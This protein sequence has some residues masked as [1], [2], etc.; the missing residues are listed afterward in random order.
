MSAKITN[1]ACLLAIAALALCALLVQGC[2]DSTSSDAPVSPAAP[3]NAPGANALANEKLAAAPPTDTTTP[4]PQ[5]TI[6][7]TPT[8]VTTPDHTPTPSA[9]P[10]PL[11]PPTPMPTSTLTPMS[12]PAPAAQCS[13]GVAVPN[14][15]NTPRLV[16]DCSALLAARDTLAGT[17][18]NLNWSSDIPISDWDG[19]TIGND[20]VSSLS[21]SHHRLDGEIPPELGNLANLEML[22]LFQNRLTGVIPPELGNLSNLTDLHLS[23][24][25]LTGEI[26]PELGN[27]SNLQTLFLSGNHLTGAI[28]PELG[29]LANLTELSLYRNELTRAIPPELGDLANLEFLYL[30]DNQLTG[31]IPPELGNLA[32]LEILHLV[33]NQLTSEIPPELGNLANLTELLLYRNELTGAIPPELGDLANLTELSLFSN[34]LTGAIPP[35]L[36]NLA[37]LEILYLYGNQLKGEIPQELGS[38]ANLTRLFLYQNELTDEI[39]PALGNLANLEILDLRYNQLTGAIPPALSNL[40]NLEYLLLDDNQLTG[41][42][43]PELGDLNNLR[44]L[45]LGVN[46]LTGEIP[47]E[48]SNLA[49]LG[50]LWISDNRLTGAIPPELGSLPNLQG[51]SLSGNQ[52]TG[53]IPPELGTPDFWQLHLN[54]NQLTGPIPPELGNLAN[55]RMLHLNDNRLSG[56]I[57]PELGN[58][59]D[60]WELY[61]SGNQLTGCIPASLRAHMN[62]D[63]IE[64]VGLPFCDAPTATP[65]PTPTST[66]TITPTPTPTPWAPKASHAPLHLRPFTIEEWI[67]RSDAIVRVKLLEVDDYIDTDETIWTIKRRHGAELW[68]EFEVLEYLKGSGNSKIWGVANAPYYR[69]ATKEEAKA[70]AKYLQDTRDTRWDDRE[71]IVFLSNE[72]AS[73]SSTSHPDRYALSFFIPGKIPEASHSLESVGGWFPLTSPNGSFGASEDQRLM[74]IDPDSKAVSHIAE[75]TKRWRNTWRASGAFE[76]SDMTTMA[77]SDLKWL[78]ANESELLRIEQEKQIAT[79]RNRTAPQ[80]LTAT[81][82]SAGIA[83]RWTFVEA[84]LYFTTSYRISRKASGETEF[85][86]ISDVQPQW[87]VIYEDTTATEPG[88]T[89][90]YKV[91]AILK[92]DIYSRFNTSFGEYGGEAQVS[93][94][95]ADVHR[96]PTPT[97]TPTPAISVADQ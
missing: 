59:S 11:Y 9:T 24:N 33:D 16:A 52:L 39:P 85:T 71:A 18:R 50:G 5:Y 56:E 4:K 34:N 22:N 15:E 1:R 73:I 67:L 36:G 31:A 41:A 49:N 14:S 28:P 37:N 78:I 12:T 76:S 79:V 27:L 3:E 38:L 94:T 87:N 68:F 20:G 69:V 60:L 54:D 55:I 35:E 81:Q 29:N 93:I 51:L 7:P 83:L 25:D 53:E 64:L 45:S 84:D 61:L 75:D 89:Y 66:P 88:V 65:T 42:I 10:I 82:T 44:A 13:N 63:E 43:P 92:D 62:S 80:E 2:A 46:Q 30:D 8:S 58:L 57:P 96:T 77:V 6:S 70:V 26:P 97:A 40:A 21:L 47:D 74:L 48:L 91:T 17:N 23:G 90:T 19:V 86:K 95:T 32:N 72:N